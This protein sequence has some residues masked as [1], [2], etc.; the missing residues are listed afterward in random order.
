MSMA[1]I[2]V[3]ES[4]SLDGVAQGLGRPDEDTRDGFDRGGWGPAYTDAVMM[5]VM[6]GGMATTAAMLFGRRTYLDFH[7]VWAGRTDGNP[8]TEM[9]DKTPKYVASRTLDDPLPWQ[10]SILL[11]GDAQQSV[12]ALKTDLKEDVVVLGSGELVRSLAAAGLVDRYVL[13]IHPLVLG[14]GRR[15]FAEKGPL[16]RLRLTD[17]VPTTTGVLIATYDVER[18]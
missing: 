13:S 2:V 11:T 10:N 7:Q 15:F 9:L 4:V 1:K 6:G 18:E 16:G 17:S 12:A 5:E 14:A 3:T 8:F